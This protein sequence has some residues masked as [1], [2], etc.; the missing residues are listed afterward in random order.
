MPTGFEVGDRVE[1]RDGRRLRTLWTRPPASRSFTVDDV[2]D[3]TVGRVVAVWV[4]DSVYTVGFEI[5]GIRDE[6]YGAFDGGELRRA[7]KPA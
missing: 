1:I 3:G 2:K 6:V 5:P 7:G 4:G